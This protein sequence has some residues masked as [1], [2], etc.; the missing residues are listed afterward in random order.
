[1][2]ESAIQFEI[3]TK[4]NIAFSS[5]RPHSSSWKIVGLAE[6]MKAAMTIIGNGM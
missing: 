2:L 6:T 5:F 3:P 1:M 4:T